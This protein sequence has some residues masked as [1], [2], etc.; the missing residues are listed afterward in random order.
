MA[1]T[2]RP[3]HVH[4]V[5]VHNL[6]LAARYSKFKTPAG[7]PWGGGDEDQFAISLDYWLRW[8]SLVKL[9]YQTQKGE[10]NTFFGQVVVG[11]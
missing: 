6:E 5:F 11:F 10:P 7:A 4:N 3:S 8:N 2:I 1:A 9:T